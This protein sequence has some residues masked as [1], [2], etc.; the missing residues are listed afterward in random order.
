[1][2]LIVGGNGFLGLETA[3]QLLAEGYRVRSM[4]RK[5]SRAG[6]LH[7]LDVEI[8]QGDLID[9]ASLR[10]ACQ[11]V[12]HII[13][14]AHSLNGKGRYRSEAV[15]DTGHRTLI[16]I[17]KSAGVE[18]FIYTS[19]YGARPDH[20]VDFLRTKYH[21]EEYL[22]ASGLTYTILRPTAFM[23]WHVHLLN[24]KSILERGKTLILGDG[25]KPR[26]FVAVRDVARFA[27]RAMS[28]PALKNR[29]LEIGGPD[30]LTNNRVAD[31]YGAFS[32]ITPKIIHVPAVAAHL[33]SRLI[34]PFH[35][36][37]SRILY[38]NSLPDEDFNET[39]KP[40]DLLAEFPMRLTTVEEFVKE[41]VGARN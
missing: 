32:G 22:K 5:P 41:K 13:T 2:V 11:G 31:L 1:M 33:L 18:H 3:K 36:G 12:T 30:N 7:D 29:T 21:V 9:V 15:D 34:K 28:E 24:G 20:V 27:V 40:G 26:N 23:E 4:V 6:A 8:V 10:R 39:F 16:D 19:I 35:S 17:A 14:A 25:L 37:I 38:L